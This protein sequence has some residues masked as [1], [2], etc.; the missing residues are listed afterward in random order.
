MKLPVGFV[1][2]PG[3]HVGLI[4]RT[5]I[6]LVA[7][8]QQIPVIVLRIPE[9]SLSLFVVGTSDNLTDEVIS[10]HA[11]GEDGTVAPRTKVKALVN[12]NRSAQ[13]VPLLMNDDELPLSM[14][15]VDNRAFKRSFGPILHIP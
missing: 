15:L 8:Q 7:R 12:I 2:A 11:A 5:R 13:Y 10:C 9:Q 6:A 14:R 3:H 4:A 1:V